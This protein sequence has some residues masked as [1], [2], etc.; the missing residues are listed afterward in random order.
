M[1]QLDSEDVIEQLTRTAVGRHLLH[2]AVMIDD[3]RVVIKDASGVDQETKE[4]VLASLDH[5]ADPGEAV[6]YFAFCMHLAELRGAIADQ[7]GFD[8]I[9]QAMNDA[10]PKMPILEPATVVH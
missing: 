6:S 4:Q 5:I 7:K 1:R 10:G 2:H 3:V 8:R 9:L